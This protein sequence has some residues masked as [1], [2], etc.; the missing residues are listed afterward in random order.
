[1]LSLKLTQLLYVLI[2]CPFITFSQN[3]ISCKDL[4]NG[5]FYFYSQSSPARLIY[6][7]KQE[8]QIEKDLTTGDSTFWE[9]EWLND[10]TYS[11]QYKGGGENEGAYY[12]MFRK[13]KG[14]VVISN[15]TSNYYVYTMYLD[16]E[17]DIVMSSD[18]LWIKEKKV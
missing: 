16:K 2:L 18:T 3:P 9:V 11:L 1:M 5:Q 6:S 14:I 12:A 7:R 10:C 13:H 8:V 15:I 17:S 4:H